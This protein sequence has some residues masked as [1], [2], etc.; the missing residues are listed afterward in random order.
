MENQTE[1]TCWTHQLTKTHGGTDDALMGQ[2]H[3]TSGLAAFVALL[4][5]GAGNGLATFILSDTSSI[6]ILILG[7]LACIAGALIPDF[8]NTSSTAK[9]SMGIFGEPI[10]FAFRESSR[11]IQTIHTKADAK[12]RA[13]AHDAVHRGFWH[14]LVG[15]VA[16]ALIVNTLTSNPL[17]KSIQIP[18]GFVGIPNLAALLAALFCLSSLHIALSGLNLGAFKAFKATKNI[19]STLTFIVSVALVLLFF[20]NTPQDQYQ[21][22][23]Y[24]LGAGAIVHILGDAFTKAGVPL[25]SPLLPR[26]GKLW[27]TYRFATFEAKSEALNSGV[28]WGSIAIIIISSIV[29]FQRF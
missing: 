18:L 1:H 8:D 3:A 19:G 23:G 20:N 6:G 27:Y 13:K 26:K 9:S 11:I 16:L 10:T 28:I 29:L 22:I 25:F 17:T 12:S 7:G 5:F 2:A 4:A 14:S 24:S 21:W 15:A